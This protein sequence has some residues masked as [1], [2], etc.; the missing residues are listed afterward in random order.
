M[1]RTVRTAFLAAA[2]AAVVPASEANADACDNATGGQAGLDECYAK[3]AKKADAELNKL[4]KEIEARLTDDP[5]TR[6]LLVTA[7]RA[8]IGFRDAE[9]ALRGSGDGSVAPMNYAICQ[10]S[11]TEDRI[12]D[13][14]DDLDCAEGDVTCVIPAA[15]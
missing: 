14:K 11:L 5:D 3:V 9:C 13:F 10:A 7:Q 12:A 4:Y 6:K 8:W 15:N 2:L 1:L